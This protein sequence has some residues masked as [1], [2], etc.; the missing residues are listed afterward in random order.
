M[1]KHDSLLNNKEPGELDS[2]VNTNGG[3]CMSFCIVKNVQ[4]S[5]CT[6]KVF[7]STNARFLSFFIFFDF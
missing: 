4:T 2:V 3:F 5:Y 1:R 7:I 6:E